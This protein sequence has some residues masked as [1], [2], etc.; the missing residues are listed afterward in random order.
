ML[1]ALNEGVAAMTKGERARLIVMLT[2]GDQWASSGDETPTTPQEGKGYMLEVE[3]VDFTPAH[4]E[5]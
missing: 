1:P 5:L 3:L 4:D 2:G